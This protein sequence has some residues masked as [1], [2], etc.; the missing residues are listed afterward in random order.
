M[1]RYL[2]RNNHN[3]VTILLPSFLFFLSLFLKVTFFNSLL[4]L[5]LCH[6]YFQN[7]CKQTKKWNLEIDKVL[8]NSHM[9]SFLGI[10]SVSNSF[11]R[12]S[13]CLRHSST[14]SFQPHS[15]VNW[16]FLGMKPITQ[17]HLHA[18]G[19]SFWI[20]FSVQLSTYVVMYTLLHIWW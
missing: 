13:K 9:A 10:R 3:W 12:Y 2:I 6:F 18:K 7:Y 8:Q 1:T 14:I 20:L 5:L 11:H 15:Q 4:S 16:K 17:S 19:E